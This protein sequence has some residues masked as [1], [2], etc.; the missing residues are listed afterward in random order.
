MEED[1]FLLHAMVT[2]TAPI[3]PS[4]TNST[5]QSTYMLSIS[6]K[7]EVTFV[8]ETV[9]RAEIHRPLAVFVT[10]WVSKQNMK[11]SLIDCCFVPIRSNIV[12]STM[13]STWIT[14]GSL[15]MIRMVAANAV[16][17]AMVRKVV[18]SQEAM[19]KL[20][21]CVYLYMHFCPPLLLKTDRQN[22]A[23]ILLTIHCI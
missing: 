14:G 8:T 7:C 6:M 9:F 2:I 13:N 18:F 5:Q 21:M 20:F 11:K 10:Q 1:F 4:N 23:K 3:W 16:V 12:S 22:S 17:C 15:E 19:I